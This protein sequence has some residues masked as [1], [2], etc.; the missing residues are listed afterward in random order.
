[1]DLIKKYKFS[2]VFLIL[3]IL[4]YITNN[5]LGK[6]ATIITINNIKEMLLL[7]PPIFI[8]MELLEVWIPKEMLIKYMGNGAKF[9]GILIAFTL[10]TV[11]AGPI[12]VAFPM[13]QLL[14]KK[15]ARLM[16]VIFFLAVWSSTKFIIILTEL[17][18]LGVKFTVVQVAVFLP[19]S[20]LMSYLIEKS[21]NEE[22][23]NI[24]VNK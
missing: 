15:G 20:L 6:T 18:S 9:T 4:L 8:T 10:G 11:A 14:L 23:L 12:Y 21:V 3:L 24:I 5:D 2:I 1:M 7:V 13:G 17:A 19:F 22:E 16:Y